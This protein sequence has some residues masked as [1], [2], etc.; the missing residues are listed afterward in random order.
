MWSPASVSIWY[1][2]PIPIKSL[3]LTIDIA[4]KLNKTFISFLGYLSQTKLTKIFRATRK[5]FN[6]KHDAPFLFYDN[7]ICHNPFYLSWA[8]SL[9]KPVYKMYIYTL[10]Q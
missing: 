7:P 5:A 9:G 2:L 3:S 6:K 4:K 10:I 8:S 1:F